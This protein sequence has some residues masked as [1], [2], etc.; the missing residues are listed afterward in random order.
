VP[1]VVGGTAAA[2]GRTLDAAGFKHAPNLSQA[3]PHGTSRIVFAQEPHGGVQAKKGSYVHV[4]WKA[5]RS[6]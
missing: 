2:A 1:N 3:A 6:R 5:Q 4:H